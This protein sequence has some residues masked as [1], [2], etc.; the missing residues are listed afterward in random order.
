[1]LMIDISILLYF[2]RYSQE[3][4]AL[5]FLIELR[6]K[7]ASSLII[8]VLYQVR[9]RWYHLIIGVFMNQSQ[10]LLLNKARV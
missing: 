6:F 7:D 3:L 1:M 10:I 4:I 5:F 9:N 8:T 2:M